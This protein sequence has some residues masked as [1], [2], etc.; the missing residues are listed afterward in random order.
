MNAV[1]DRPGLFDNSC[2]LWPLSDRAAVRPSS[3]ER[4]ERQPVELIAVGKALIGRSLEQIHRAQG[5]HFHAQLVD[6]V[7]GRADLEFGPSLFVVVRAAFGAACPD[8]V[9]EHG[10]GKETQPRQSE[11][12][13]NR[14]RS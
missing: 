14:R 4:E 3:V 11:A 9:V 10:A 2:W 5:R 13:S 1:A 7:G 8:G 12:P 6:I